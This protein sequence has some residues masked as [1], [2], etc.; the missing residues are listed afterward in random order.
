MSKKMI[1]VVLLVAAWC[2]GIYLGWTWGEI[3]HMNGENY[4]LAYPD[5]QS[6]EFRQDR[7]MINLRLENR[8]TDVYR[9]NCGQQYPH[10]VYQDNPL[11]FFDGKPVA[12]TLKDGVQYSLY[13]F[14]DKWGY[15]TVVQVNPCEDGTV[16]VAIFTT[17]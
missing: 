17:P 14:P 6:V 10:M 2:S 7:V 11:I 8:Q 15:V 16:E 5:I 1:V 3:R 9:S 12:Y 13:S 4:A